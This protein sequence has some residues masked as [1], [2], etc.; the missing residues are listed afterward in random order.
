[1]GRSRLFVW[2]CLV[3]LAAL[4][5][6]A[7]WA[8]TITSPPVS[9]P[10]PPPQAYIG[11]PV[12]ELNDAVQ[13]ENADSLVTESA[14]NSVLAATGHVRVHY[15]SFELTSDRMDLDLDR[16]TADFRG[17]LEL[18]GPF[19]QTVEGSPNSVLHL[20]LRDGSYDIAGAHAVIPPD[21]L[22]QSYD[23][24]ILLPLRID[25]GSLTGRPGLIQAYGGQFTTCDFV[26]PHYAFEAAQVYLIP[27]K[28]LVAKRV[29]LLR[30][31]HRIFTYPY[32][33]VPLDRRYAGVRAGCGPARHPSCRCDA[34][35]GTWHWLRAGLRVNVESESRQR[36][37]L[38]VS[39]G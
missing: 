6:S 8:Q 10:N 20:N 2:R 38:T 11:E 18:T 26:I 36:P 39:P 9:A 13:L 25:G 23:S 3:A 12:G 14:D 19:Q 21:A 7:S 33:Y 15:R 28:R 31:G 30:K 24:G 17:H 22:N 1:M 27:N 35:E 29:S 37:L 32:V 4:A 34:K 16:G 5:Q